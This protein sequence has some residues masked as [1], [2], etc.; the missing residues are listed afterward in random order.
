MYQNVPP[1]SSQH[2][3]QIKYSRIRIGSSHAFY[4]SGD[5]IIMLIAVLIVSDRLFLNTF[6]C[7]ISRN[8]DFTV[9]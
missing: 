5:N 8:V 2:F 7:Y 1:M 9:L 6:G 4:E 3:G